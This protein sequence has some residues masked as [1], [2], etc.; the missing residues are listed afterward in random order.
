MSPDSYRGLESI[1]AVGAGRL[2]FYGPATVIPVAR[3]LWQHT[4]F[5]SPHAWALVWTS[6]QTLFRLIWHHVC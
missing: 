6:F 3:K 1:T 4:R 5:L 2:C